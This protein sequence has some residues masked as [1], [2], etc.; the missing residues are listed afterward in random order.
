MRLANALAREIT[1]GD[2]IYEQFQEA[3]FPPFSTADI[4]A[5]SGP[6]EE[7]LDCG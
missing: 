4:E 6:I 1:R 7:V 5:V 2:Q 3:N